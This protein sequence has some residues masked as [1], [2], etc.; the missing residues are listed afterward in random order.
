M[1]ERGWKFEKG[2]SP[3]LPTIHQSGSP[4]PK[5][6]IN[7]DILDYLYEKV[8]PEEKGLLKISDFNLSFLCWGRGSAFIE[9]NITSGNGGKIDMKLIGLEAEKFITL[10]E[11]TRFE[12]DF[13]NN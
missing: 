9:I 5:E 7:Q 10:V 13:G 6:K 11:K 4:I 3:E 8:S 12:D 2:N 1:K